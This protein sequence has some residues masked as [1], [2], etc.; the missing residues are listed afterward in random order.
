MFMVLLMI[1]CAM[2]ISLSPAMAQINLSERVSHCR[3]SQL[4]ATEDSKES[5]QLEGGLG[6]FAKTIE[7]KNLSSSPCSL[8]GVPELRFLDKTNRPLGVHVC[9]NCGDYVF[10][11][12][13]V[14]EV[15]LEPNESA[16]LLVGFDVNDGVG[17]CRN[18]DRLSLR[19]AGQR[20][21]RINTDGFRTCGGVDITPFIARHDSMIH[22]GR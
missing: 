18:A 15:L 11:K 20:E 4:S 2:A 7:I 19:I 10:P 6:H 12:G 13:P 1:L 17:P 5:D 3:A 8:R 9:P 22:T 21:L 16:Y 14:R